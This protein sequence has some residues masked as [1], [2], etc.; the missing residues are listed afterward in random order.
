MEYSLRLRL[1]P[2]LKV[3][4][5]E[6]YQPEGIQWMYEHETIITYFNDEPL[7]YGGLVADEVGLGKTLLAISTMLLNPKPNTLIIL[8]KSLVFQWKEQIDKFTDHIVVHVVTTSKDHIEIDKN[9]NRINVFLFS[10]SLLNKKHSTAGDSIAHNI[11]WDRIFI[12]E[13]HVLRNK[14][15]KFYDSC[16]MLQSEIKWALT[17]TPVMNRMS[18]FVNIMEWVG[19]SRHT[20]QTEKDYVTSTFIL[21]RTKE[22]VKS[23][24]VQNMKCNVQVKKIPFVTTE[25]AAIYA[26]VYHQERNMIKKKNQKV[27]VP[28][29]LEHL[30]RVRQLCIH[31]QLYLDG[32]S[33]KKQSDFGNWDTLVTKI[34]E[35]KKCI[36]SQPIDDKCII[37]CQFVQ[38]IDKYE[39]ALAQIGVS[40]VRLDGKMNMN[41]RN[42]SVTKFKTNSTI[43]AFIIQINT[44]G[45]GINLQN[46]NHI[47][48]MSPNWN[49]AVEYQAIGRAYRTGQTKTVH[50]TKF[51]ITSGTQDTPFIEENIIELQD[52][53]KKII[54]HLLNDPRIVD[55]GLQI[56]T[57]MS[58]GLSALDIMKLFNLHK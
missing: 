9:S 40:S 30:L 11:Q 23:S 17:A 18:D 44:G 28:D 16:S 20:C 45:Q 10:Q 47:Y 41:E 50:V 39:K 27:N 46:A 36:Q 14:K 57:D 19:V 32:M 58:V 24:N 31:P 54:A 42:E 43:K 7:P 21:R 2:L 33:K 6:P 12:D 56:N 34:Q 38:E 25:E 4:L 3:N 53:K 29:L 35:L 52:R 37:F 13:A 22:D 51:C 55:D 8:P 5:I 49:P 48:I 15:S 1:Y 26:K